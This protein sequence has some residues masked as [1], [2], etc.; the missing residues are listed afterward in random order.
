MSN[1]DCPFCAEISRRCAVDAEST[2]VA[3]EV[4][5]RR[6]GVLL[7][8]IFAGK[9]VLDLN[10]DSTCRLFATERLTFDRCVAFKAS[11]ASFDEF[12]LRAA[13]S[14][15][16]E[17]VLGIEPELLPTFFDT[18]GPTATLR[19]WVTEAAVGCMRLSPELFDRSAIEGASIG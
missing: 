14:D 7:P 3:A 1:C 12:S 9:L 18:D 2:V 8:I 17:A 15:A 16:R 11:G 13:V 4:A 6:V 19:C 10:A 5:V